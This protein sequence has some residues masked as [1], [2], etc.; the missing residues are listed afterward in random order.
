MSALDRLI[1]S[2]NNDPVCDEIELADG[3]LKF[4]YV[5]KTLAD[6]QK[7]E[8]L[9]KGNEVER[10]L[11]T[12]IF[13]AKDEA[14]DPLFTIADKQKLKRNVSSDL[15]SDMVIKMT[16]DDEELAEK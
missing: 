7:I 6:I 5:P 15:L 10:L 9:A 4:C 14:G 3:A 1:A 16:V 12:V 13:M 2:T 11:Y 8:R